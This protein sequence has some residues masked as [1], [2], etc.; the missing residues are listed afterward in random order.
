MGP[1]PLTRHQERPMTPPHAVTP[2]PRSARRSNPRSLARVLAALA[3][4]G[5]AVAA[6]G[7]ASADDLDATPATLGSVYASAQGGDVIHLAAGNYGT[8]SGASKSAVVTLV[9]QAGAT[10]TISPSLGAGVS[11]L[12]FDG[13]TIAGAYTN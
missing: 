2:A 4:L 10:A 13:L 8:F 9:A 3:V 6:A 7:P 1:S 5:A 12:R 11:N